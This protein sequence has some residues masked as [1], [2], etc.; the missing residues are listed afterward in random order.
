MSG[1]QYTWLKTSQWESQWT[2]RRA[3][4]RKVSD[5]SVRTENTCESFFQF[6]KII[7]WE[8]QNNNKIY[9]DSG[10]ERKQFEV[11]ELGGVPCC[12]RENHGLPDC[13]PA[14]VSPLSATATYSAPSSNQPTPALLQKASIKRQPAWAFQLTAQKREGGSNTSGAH[15]HH[16]WP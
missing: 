6:F 3:G 12:I 15:S 16:L 14:T 9:P 1:T 13:L 4:F 2:V 7:Q 8:N 5:I 11:F 10:R